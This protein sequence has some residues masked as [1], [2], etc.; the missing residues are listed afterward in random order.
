MRKWGGVTYAIPSG[1]STSFIHF[2]HKLWG[3]EE[4]C[5]RALWRWIAGPY[6]HC[7]KVSWTRKIS[8]VN[9]LMLQSEKKKLRCVHT[10][11]DQW[12]FKKKGSLY[13][14]EG[15]QAWKWKCLLESIPWY[16]LHIESTIQ[17]E[18]RNHWE[19]GRCTFPDVCMFSLFYSPWSGCYS[20]NSSV[21]SV[22]MDIFVFSF[23]WI[24][25]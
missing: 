1:F 20:D 23:V 4:K 2:V 11:G 14:G 15:D 21:G 25:I 3:Q 8:A 5:N 16:H 12:G 18:C 24:H 9:L 7:L 22:K 6:N 17:P 13:V 19:V 10:E